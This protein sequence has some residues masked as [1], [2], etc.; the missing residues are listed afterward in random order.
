MILGRLIRATS[1]ESYSIIRVNW[2][3]KIF[4]G[5]DI[6]SFLVQALGA[7]MLSGAKTQNSKKRGE[8]VILAG[9][10]FQIVI[11]CFF[12]LVA[13]VFHNRLRT[14]PTEKSTASGLPWERLMFML[15]GVSVLITTR[16]VFRV[17]EYAMGG[18][19][20]C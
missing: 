2:V 14:R 20:F 19:F 7:G 8:T 17:I 15:Y 5:G 4:V 6:F 13:L 16:N 3:T 10:I 11:F 18:K 12:I 1:A 9:L